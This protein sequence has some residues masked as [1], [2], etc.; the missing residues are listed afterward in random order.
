[1]R[2]VVIGAGLLGVATAYYL[3]RDGHEVIVLDRRQ[4]PGLETSFA[5]GGMLTPSQS[6]PWNVPG[7]ALQVIRWLGRAQSPILIKPSALFSIAGWGLAFLHNSS[8]EKFRE[9]QHKNYLLADYNIKCLQGIRQQHALSYDGA[10]QGTMKIYRNT[11]AFEDAQ[12]LMQLFANQ[13]TYE[14]LDCNGVIHHEPALTG[15][16]DTI[17]GGIYFPED[18]SGDA[19]KFCAELER[20]TREYGVTYLYQTDVSGI[21]KSDRGVK[22]L[23]TSAGQIQADRFILAAGSYSS[24]LARSA[25]FNLP[26]RPV[27]GYSL[28]LDFIGTGSGL[29]LPIIDESRHIA[30]TPLGERVRVAG[31]AELAGYD[32]SINEK[33]IDKIYSY[34][35]EIYP[36]A[37]RRCRIDSSQKWTGLRPYSCDGVP[38]IGQSPLDNLYLNTGH[39]HLGWSMAVGSARLLA[40]WVSNKEAEID[41]K[42]YQLDRFD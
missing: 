3:A 28:T 39:G 1:M 11:A 4:G 16:K 19:Y 23:T 20:I 21:I 29:T 7:I 15:V 8:P 5:N 41:L 14:L 35:T 12:H 17:V 9:N 32:T 24:L 42:P 10:E 33:R 13:H 27:K 18:E 22:A 37:S 30:I 38:I 25:G 6:A 2:I 40:D 31:M 34:F 36:E 26:I